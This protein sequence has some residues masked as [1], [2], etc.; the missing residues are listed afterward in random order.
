MRYLRIVHRTTSS[1]YFTIVIYWHLFLHLRH[2]SLT[3][4]ECPPINNFNFD[5]FSTRD[6]LV[7]AP[8][9][10]DMRQVEV[11]TNLPVLNRIHLVTTMCLR[12]RP[13][14]LRS[15]T[16]KLWSKIEKM[17]K[18]FKI[19]RQRQARR[20]KGIRWEQSRLR[21]NL[22]SFHLIY[23]V[24]KSRLQN[25]FFPYPA[26]SFLTGLKQDYVSPL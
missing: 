6:F 3:G 12:I 1:E 8:T 4:I 10:S 17:R 7:Q 18:E 19:W 24:Q 25:D 20:W 21:I 11:P 16:P 5:R 22:K 13:K 9:L 23:Q 14:S 2:F 26:S 15:S